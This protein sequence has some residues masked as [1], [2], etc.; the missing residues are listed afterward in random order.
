MG[1][2]NTLSVSISAHQKGPVRPMVNFGLRFPSRPFPLVS[3]LSATSLRKM[4]RENPAEKALSL[5]RRRLCGPNFFRVRSPRPA[6]AP[7]CFWVPVVPE[8][9]LY[10]PKFSIVISLQSSYN[11]SIQLIFLL[12]SCF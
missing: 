9:L 12:Y 6:T 1:L 3:P 5:L 11:C 4:A 7:F 10:A 8:K 2:I